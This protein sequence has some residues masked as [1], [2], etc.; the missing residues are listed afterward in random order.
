MCLKAR[1]YAVFRF[2]LC[3]YHYKNA[4]CYIQVFSAS[5]YYISI[6]G[7]T[8]IRKKIF[9]GALERNGRRPIDLKADMS[10]GEEFIGTG[11]TLAFLYSEG[12]WDFVIIELNRYVM[13]GDR[14]P[15]MH[16]T[17]IAFNVSVA[18]TF[19]KLI[20]FIYSCSGFGLIWCGYDCIRQ[21]W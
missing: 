5:R 18:K 12:K 1:A 21:S 10:L 9:S 13:C 4:K 15:I 6:L 11:I 20:S 7:I 8:K 16:F 3:M 17:K 19:A 14:I 2:I